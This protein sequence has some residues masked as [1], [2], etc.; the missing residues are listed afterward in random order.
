[1][2]ERTLADLLADSYAF[3]ELF[4]GNPRYARIFR[5]TTIATTALNVVEIYST[6][7]QRVDPIVALRHARS[8]L[9]LSVEVPETAAL[10]A[11]EFRGR[12]RSLRRD[13]ST[14]DAWGFAASRELGMK[15]LTGDPA[16]K[17]LDGVE[18]L[19]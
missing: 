15:F 19:R 17:G 9:A 10:V 7:L 3:F 2:R 8:C 14:V 5:R 13:C 4:A 18:F 6:L 12:M 16:F 1:M 11:G